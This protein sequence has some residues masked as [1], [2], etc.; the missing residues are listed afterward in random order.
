M[1]ILAI[2]R[3][4][5]RIR[6]GRGQLRSILFARICYLYSFLNANEYYDLHVQD[7]FR[8]SPKGLDVGP[9]HTSFVSKCHLERDK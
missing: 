7:T 4:E 9:I 8:D 6:D 5:V 1:R 3:G 2:A